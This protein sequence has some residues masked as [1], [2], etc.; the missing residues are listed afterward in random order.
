MD[1][2]DM[3]GQFRSVLRAVLIS[4]R[5]CRLDSCVRLRFPGEARDRKQSR[6]CARQQGSLGWLMGLEPTT[7]RIT[8]WDSTN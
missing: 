1:S 5:A 2:A 3:P 7:T 4:R 6:P 8:T